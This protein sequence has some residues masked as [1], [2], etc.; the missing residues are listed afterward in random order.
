MKK[1]LRMTAGWMCV[2]LA[3]V[4]FSP[5]RAEANP[6]LLA[7]TGADRGLVGEYGY[8]A[9]D[10]AHG[11]RLIHLSVTSGADGKLSLAYT[12]TR[13]ANPDVALEGS[14]SGRV[15]A[16]G[17]LH[18]DYED[19]FENRGTGTLRNVPHGCWV[20]IDIKTV[21]DTRCLVFYGDLTLERE[22]RQTR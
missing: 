12:G 2:G 16:R 15:D 9:M 8:H 22:R 18:F 4:I 20:S 7:S 13:G 10:E 19:N 5:G 21:A 6:I 11:G 3:P 14:G 17:V 1:I